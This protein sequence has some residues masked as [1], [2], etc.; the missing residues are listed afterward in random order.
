MKWL[1]VPAALLG[2]EAVLFV[3]ASVYSRLCEFVFLVADFFAGLE[4]SYIPAEVPDYSFAVFLILLAVTGAGAYSVRRERK[5]FFLAFIFSLI[6]VIMLLI[7]N[8][9]YNVL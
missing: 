1:A 3:F 6:S 2:I 7:H 4:Y 9:V 8:S 5:I